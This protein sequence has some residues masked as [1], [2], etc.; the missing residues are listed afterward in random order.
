M[1]RTVITFFLPHVSPCTLRAKTKARYNARYA[2]KNAVIGLCLSIILL[3]GCVATTNDQNQLNTV[4][5][6]ADAAQLVR[7]GNTT[8]DGGDLNSAAALYRRAHNVEPEWLDP[9]LLLGDTAMRMRVY[10]D[11]E[12]AYRAA[13]AIDAA[14]LEATLG[15]GRV[16][17]QVGQYDGA[18]SQ[19]RSTIAI[20]P[21]DGR[22]Y[23]GAAVSL[24]L[25]GDYATAQTL[26][27]QAIAINPERISLYNNFGLSLALSG[28]YDEAIALLSDMLKRGEGNVQ[29]RQH[30]SL[31]YGLANEEDSAAN[32]ARMDLSEPEVQNNL[33]YYRRLRAL[34]PT[35]RAAAVYGLK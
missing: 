22:G 14:N 28:A 30:L 27:H 7:L 18:L 17:L 2:S 6:H 3:G 5:E 34:D 26:Y 32:I 23:N 13:L 33:A 35:A 25:V 1:S 9:L 24:D 31:V 11:A 12:T 16:L 10:A 4:Q 21:M 29:S 15:L 20:A 8:R 19:F